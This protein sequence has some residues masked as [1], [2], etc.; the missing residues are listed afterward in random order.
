[1]SA[2]MSESTQ[3]AEPLV[4]IGLPVYNGEEFLAKSIA[5][6]LGQTYRNIELIIS[7]NASTDGTAGI[8]QA[9][10]RND[11]RVRYSRLPENIGGVRNHSRV[12]ELAQGEFF[13]WASCDDLWLPEYVAECLKPLLADPRTV[14]AYAINTTIDTQDRVTGALP[15]GPVLSVDDPAI[16]FRHLI[17]IYIGIQP[18][19]GVIRMSALRKVRRLQLHPGFDRIAFA[20]LGLYGKLQ[21]VEQPIYLRRLHENQS[22]GAYPSLRSRYRW[23][24]PARNPRWVLP[25][26]EYLW[27]F[28]VAAM[29]AAPGMRVRLRCMVELLRWS[30]W[31]RKE[32]LS[33][34]LSRS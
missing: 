9:F 5:S 22:V 6:L 20:E 27:G 31:R 24:D 21:K 4:S 2:S 7:D 29:R 19:Y 14:V 12:I 8:C 10:A 16:R 18:F 33:D 32:L 1:M 3:R 28:F 34:I 30:V 11:P 25:H 17:D 23:I 15:P 13:M 26:F